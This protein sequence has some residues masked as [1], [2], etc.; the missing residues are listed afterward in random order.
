MERR[1]FI[2]STSTACAGAVLI[3]L[4]I[5][6]LTSCHP[7]PVFKT[8][9]DEPLVSIPKT[10]FVEGQKL[11]IVR[12]PKLEFDVLLVKKDTDKYS[13]LYMQC[14]HETQPLNATQTGLHCA[15]H[16]SSFD[17]DG[18]VVLQP[19]TKPLRR[20]WVEQNENTVTVHLNKNA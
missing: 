8:E 3:G 4:A 15:S 12:H 16:G 9:S 14:T 5:T 7:L 2:K 6:S 1:N 17:L 10:Q 19:A 11:L 18:N 20:F 13:A